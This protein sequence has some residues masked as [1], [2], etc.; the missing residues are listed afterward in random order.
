MYK[1]TFRYIRFDNWGFKKVDLAE[2]SVNCRLVAKR[3][4]HFNFEEP[5]RTP[6][7]KI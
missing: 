3:P 1:H 7:T 2:Q 5:Q 4:Q 6:R